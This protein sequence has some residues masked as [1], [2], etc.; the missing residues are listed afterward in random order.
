MNIGWNLDQLFDKQIEHCLLLGR[1]RSVFPAAQTGSEGITISSY[2]ES[3]QA[4]GCKAVHH[5]L[6]SRVG[7][8]MK[9]L[10]VY[11]TMVVIWSLSSLPTP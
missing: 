8:L 4:I 5:V 9:S 10:Y 11:I 1:T 6:V 3:G 7:Q 2:W